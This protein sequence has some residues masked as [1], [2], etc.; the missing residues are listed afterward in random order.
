MTL[1]WLVV[2]VLYPGNQ[3][4]TELSHGDFEVLSH[5][6]TRSTASRLDIPFSPDLERTSPCWPYP[7]KAERLARK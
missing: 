4:V 1:V 3:L 6:E 7:N 5:W 2:G